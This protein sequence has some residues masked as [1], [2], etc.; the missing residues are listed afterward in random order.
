MANTVVNPTYYARMTQAFLRSRLVCAS[1]ANTRFEANITPGKVIEFPYSAT[2][3]VQDYTFSTDSTI[4]DAAFTSDQLTVDQVK[5]ATQNYDPL[6]NLQAHDPAWMDAN[7]EEMAYQLSRN[8][9]QFCLT[10]FINDAAGTVVGGTLSTSTFFSLMT[11]VT[12]TISRQRGND[13]VPFAILDPERIGLLAQIDVANGF[14]RADS[15]LS[16]GFVGT[17]S[18]GF[19]VYESNDLPSTVVLTVDTIPTATDTFDLLGYTWTCIADGATAAA[20]EIKVGANLADFQA[21]F[22]ALVNNTTIPS[23]G[24]FV[25]WG[26]DQEREYLNAQVTAGAWGADATTITAYGKIGGSEAFTTGTNVF[27]TET[28]S[29]LFGMT[30]APSLVV[31][32]EPQIEERKEPANKSINILGT[33]MYGADVFTR[34]KQRLVKMTY[35]V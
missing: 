26:T 19:N 8:I 20:G 11:D 27:G 22:L 15:A 10:T 31:Q 17:T 16:N 35:N 30:G 7:A 5:I 1:I 14:N 2:V 4:D 33:A 28:A 6:Q 12:S 29:M 9:D 34:D 25:R 13:G 32:S 21:I 18:A 24:D 3:R 23:A